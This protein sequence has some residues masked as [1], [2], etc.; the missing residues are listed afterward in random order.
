MQEGP[1]FHDL[2]HTVLHSAAQKLITKS[3]QLA[4]TRLE[5]LLWPPPHP[6]HSSLAATSGSAVPAIGSIPAQ[7]S[8]SQGMEDGGQGKTGDSQVA[9]I[10]APSTQLPEEALVPCALHSPDDAHNAAGMSASVKGAV[11]AGAFLAA[12]CGIQSGSGACD[13]CA[14]PAPQL[15]IRSHSP[16]AAWSGRPTS[17]H[18]NVTRND[19]RE[20]VVL[21]GNEVADVGLKAMGGAKRCQPVKQGRPQW[22]RWIGLKEKLGS[23]IVPRGSTR[24][25]TPGVVL[26]GCLASYCP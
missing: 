21:R 20:C 1:L 4:C 25:S 24:G 3:W 23:G 11:N 18:E 7:P 15:H 10:A 6:A 19:G 5:P 2:P 14:S 22:E 9:S 26:C 17:D 12:G 8:N 13:D 16:V